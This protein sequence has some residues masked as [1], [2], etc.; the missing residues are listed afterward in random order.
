MPSP[1]VKPGQTMEKPTEAWRY[2]PA[3]RLG[4]AD[5]AGLGL[6]DQGSED[7][8][9]FDTLPRRWFARRNFINRTRE[10]LDG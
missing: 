1:A 4:Q 2:S 6:A 10:A 9:V 8:G 3:Q 5:Q 7:V